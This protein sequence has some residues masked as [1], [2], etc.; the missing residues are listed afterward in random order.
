MQSYKS[1][2]SENYIRFLE[3][4]D[5][6]TEKYIYPN[7]AEDAFNI[8]EKFYKDNVH[9]ISIQKKTKVGADGLMI[10]ICKLLTTHSDDNFVVNP[11]NVRIITGMSNLAWE[12]D[13]IAKSPTCFKDKIYHHG[14]LSKMDLMN[15]KNGLI[16]IDEIDTG[17]KENQVL[18]KT[19]KEAGILDVNNIKLNNNKFVFISA[20]MIRELYDLYQWGNL[21]E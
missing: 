5:T 12:N 1:A 19:L 21:H 4:D 2:E 14:K 6:A 3:G 11:L 20:T 7:Q 15:I 10:E 18:H 9:V 16:I 8:V 13:M 17:D